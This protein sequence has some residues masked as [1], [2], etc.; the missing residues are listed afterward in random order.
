MTSV[1]LRSAQL[2]VVF[3]GPIN[4]WR[5]QFVWLFGLFYDESG[6]AN[7]RGDSSGNFE[8]ENMDLKKLNQFL[9]LKKK[10]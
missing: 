10:I 1:C 6:L 8:D 9:C 4:Y 3:I 7:I 5:I 2:E